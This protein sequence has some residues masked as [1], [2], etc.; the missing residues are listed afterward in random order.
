MFTDLYCSELVGSVAFDISNICKQV[1]R[2]FN[3]T[4]SQ[5]SGPLLRKLSYK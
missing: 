2:Y 5:K 1:L 3:Y 4:V